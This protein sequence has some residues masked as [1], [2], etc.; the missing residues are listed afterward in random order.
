MAGAKAQARQ[1]RGFGFGT[2]R[3]FD[4]PISLLSAKASRPLSSRDC[5]Q[6]S[7][8]T[9]GWARREGPPI[10]AHGRWRPP[11]LVYDDR[12]RRFADALSKRNSAECGRDVAEVALPTFPH[13]IPK[14]VHRLFGMERANGV[15]PTLRKKAMIRGAALGAAGAR[16]DL[17]TSFRGIRRST[18]AAWGGVGSA[19]R[20]IAQLEYEL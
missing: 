6:G 16:H 7:Q 11:S 19:A 3:P 18:I 15:G 17:R 1:L 12:R 13:V 20:L 14:R 5:R 2:R 4:R 9:A 8:M 10:R